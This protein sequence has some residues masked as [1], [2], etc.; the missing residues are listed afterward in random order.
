M[1]SSLSPFSFPRRSLNSSISSTAE[2]F[3]LDRSSFLPRSATS[4]AFALV[5][6]W[7]REAQQ[8]REQ[9]SR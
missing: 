9:A 4:M 3:S 8:R 2:A 7:L 5:S 6:R 1:H